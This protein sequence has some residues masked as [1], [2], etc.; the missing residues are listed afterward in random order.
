MEESLSRPHQQAPPTSATQ[1]YSQ[2]DDNQSS[3]PPMGNLLGTS[4]LGGNSLGTFIEHAPPY[5]EPEREE[6]SSS[7]SSSSDSSTTHDSE[8]EDNMV[9][10]FLQYKEMNK[11]N[12]DQNSTNNGFMDDFFS[13]PAAANIE[14]ANLL[15]LSTEYTETKPVSQTSTT[16]FDPWGTNTATTSTTFDP[17]TNWEWQRFDNTETKNT[18][19]SSSIPVSKTSNTSFDP[20]APSGGSDL[21]DLMGSTPLVPSTSNQTTTTTPSNVRYPNSSGYSGWASFASTSSTS[22]KNEFWSQP[23]PQSKD[24]FGDIWGQASQKTTPQA[25]QPPAKKS[26]DPFSDL[27]SFQSSQGNNLRAQGTTAQN[28]PTTPTKPTM[29]SRP[30]YYMYG[31]GTGV[32]GGGGLGAPPRESRARS[33]SPS[34]FGEYM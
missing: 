23:Q 25:R 24:P 30:A 13:N 19:T 7:E 12:R 15:E 22:K 8:R 9:D 6:S 3:E 14:E 31:S 21:F 26:T 27:G 16:S 18:P 11:T 2:L 4:P 10:P 29:T 28:R 33:P 34:K 1:G 32:S 17:F 20:F 5:R